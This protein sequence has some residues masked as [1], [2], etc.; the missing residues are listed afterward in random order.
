MLKYAVNNRVSFTRLE[1]SRCVLYN[2]PSRSIHNNIADAAVSRL[3]RDTCSITFGSKDMAV[4]GQNR[5]LANISL[6]HTTISV[7]F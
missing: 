3:V 4:A 5:R 2:I 6:R 7:E 1:S